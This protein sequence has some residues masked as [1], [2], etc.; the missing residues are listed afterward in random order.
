LEPTVDDERRIAMRVAV[1]SLAV[2]CGA[3]A[4]TSCSSSGSQ[5]RVPAAAANAYPSDATAALCAAGLRPVYVSA[6]TLDAADANVNGYAV[7]SV[8]PSFGS[9]VK[10]GSA[11]EVRVTESVNG[12]PGAVHRPSAVLPNVAGLEVNAALRELTR[13]GLRV[14]VTAA[15]PTGALVVTSEEPAAGESIPGSSTVD[16]HIGQVGSKA[17]S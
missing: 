17:C 8:H 14:R 15:T 2:G 5:V 11:V 4:L 7:A 1:M 9:K 10:P 12:G 3:V 6:P 16:L 13:L